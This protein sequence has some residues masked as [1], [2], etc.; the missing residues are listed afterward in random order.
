MLESTT[1]RRTLLALTVIG[2]TA[3]ASPVRSM[4]PAQI[5]SLSDY[6]LCRLSVGYRYEPN[7]EAEISRR[8]LVCTSETVDCMGQGIGQGNPAMGFCVTAA[9]LQNA[10][11]ARADEDA[12]RRDY[13]LREY[14]DNDNAQHRFIWH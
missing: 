3:C 7:T 8:G 10:A 13:A 12:W 9:R 11:D 5:A 6:Q 4:S 1:S 2:L 14:G